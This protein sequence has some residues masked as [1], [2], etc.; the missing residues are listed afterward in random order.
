MLQCAGKGNYKQCVAY[1][2]RGTTPDIPLP[3]I[4]HSAFNVVGN[5]YSKSRPGKSGDNSNDGG[6]H[7]ERTICDRQN[8]SNRSIDDS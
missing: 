2:R 5:I 8:M 4:S 7:T 1:T 3:A 6:R